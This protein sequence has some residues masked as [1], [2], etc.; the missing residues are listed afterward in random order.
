[1]PK[2]NEARGDYFNRSS[3]YNQNR[4]HRRPSKWASNDISR[5]IKA[6]ELTWEKYLKDIR[7]ND[8]GVVE[9]SIKNVDEDE[10]PTFT[11]PW[12]VVGSVTKKCYWSYASEAEAQEQVDKVKN[13]VDSRIAQEKWHT[14]TYGPRKNVSESSEGAMDVADEIH[15]KRNLTKDLRAG[16]FYVENDPDYNGEATPFGVH[17]SSTGYCYGVFSNEQSAERKAAQLEQQAND[18]REETLDVRD[19]F[20]NESKNIKI[21]L[22]KLKTII[23]EAF[24]GRNDDDY[25]ADPEVY[26]NSTECQLNAEQCAG[27]GASVGH[28]CPDSEPCENEACVEERRADAE[29]AS[30]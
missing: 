24:Q 23:S 5:D 6:G 21:T 9:I 7:T 12:C 16:G 17:G 1:M 2:I 25:F 15:A 4:V 26:M 30:S 8:N 18:F 20:P 19:H 29:T 13:W 3:R 11:K 22:G 14:D 27:C 10:N 28:G